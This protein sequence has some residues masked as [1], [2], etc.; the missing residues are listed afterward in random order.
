MQRR[1]FTLAA[2]ASTVTLGLGI[3]ALS[4]TPSLAQMV[5]PQQ[6]I[7]YLILDKPVAVDAVAGKVEVI[8]FFGY[9]CPHC[10]AF[11][12]ELETWLKRLPANI[13]FKRVP[14]AFNDAAV[15]LQKMYYT[16]EALGRV[17]DMQRKV[18]TA[19][20]AEK[21]NLNTQEGIVAWA[22]KQ[23]LDQKKFVDAYTSFAVNTKVTKAKQLAN[24]F[25]IDGVPSLG[26][27]GRFYTDGTLAKG[28]T[29][30]LQV[31]EQLANE[32]KSA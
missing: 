15:P 31:A 11:E 6:G 25:K 16:L 1:Q 17:N 32:T 5:K 19:I 29:R 10:N 27:A 24:A 13:S 20:H 12:P 28:M 3:S 14:V 8:E 18:F 22:V 2:T 26:V 21:I 23:G 9:W 7:D 30:A 4:T